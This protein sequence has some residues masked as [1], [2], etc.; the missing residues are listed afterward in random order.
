MIFGSYLLLAWENFSTGIN[1]TF[2][3]VTLSK[4]QNKIYFLFTRFPQ[5]VLGV[6]QPNLVC[7]F[8]TEECRRQSILGSIGP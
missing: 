8:L 7:T 1:L 2:I 4:I 5:K 3:K 6:G